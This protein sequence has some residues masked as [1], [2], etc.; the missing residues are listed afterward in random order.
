M[1]S[2]LLDTNHISP[3]ITSGHPLRQRFTQQHAFGD[4]FRIAVPAL[5]EML[6]GIRTLPRAERNLQEWHVVEGLFTF[7]Q[8]EKQDA[9]DAADLQITLRRQGWQ[10]GTVDAL[11]ATIAL[12]YGLT[13]LTTDKDYRA[14]PKLKQDNWLT[15]QSP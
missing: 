14:V 1:I 12:R 5:T 4:S 7:H 15:A 6:F 2:Y 10:L 8:I 13:L 11:I 9:E 3:L